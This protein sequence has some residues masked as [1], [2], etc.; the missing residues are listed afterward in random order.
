[1]DQDPLPPAGPARARAPQLAPG[2]ARASR[3]GKVTVRRFC[4]Q[5]WLSQVPAGCRGSA[6]LRGAKKAVRYAVAPGKSKLL[7]FTLTKKRQRSLKRKKT[8][9]LD[10]VARNTDAANGTITRL[11]VTVKRPKPKRHRRR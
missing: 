10:V 4:P 5:R 1:V 6:K 9:A 8:L 7:R 2:G 11:D 3:K